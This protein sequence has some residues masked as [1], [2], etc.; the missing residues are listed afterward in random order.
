MSRP[1]HVVLALSGGNALGA[2]QAGALEVLSER[3]IV[4][5]RIVGTS[6]GAITGAIFAGNAPEYRMARLGDFWRVAEQHD[7][8]PLHGGESSPWES[9]ARWAGGIG[10]LLGGRPGLFVPS[11]LAEWPFWRSPIGLM[12]SSPLRDTLPRLLDFTLLNAARPPLAVVALDVETGE[13]VVFDTRRD[14]FTEDHLRASAAMP[15]LFPPVEIGGRHLVDGGLSSNL[16]LRLAF[17]GLPEGPVL[18]IALELLPAA[19]RRPGSLGEAAQRAQDLVFACQTRHALE[20]LRRE[21]AL[22]RDAGADGGPAVTLLHLAYDGGPREIAVKPLD[23]TRTAI[24][25]RWC[26]GR[27]DMARALDRWQAAVPE[28]GAHEITLVGMEPGSR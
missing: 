19:S 13:E 17:D 24:R 8:L 26:H 14:A 25:D 18:C 11:A 2:Y 27:D 20:A 7:L 22:R 6:V 1:G 9:R 4:P 28:P 16:P 15:V 21:Y 3:G 12:D 23:F 10:T 5:D